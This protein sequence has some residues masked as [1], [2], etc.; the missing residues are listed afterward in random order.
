M[1][2]A[3]RA[4]R[5]SNVGADKYTY[6][7]VLNSSLPSSVQYPVIT[8]ERESSG[9]YRH[10]GNHATRVKHTMDLRSNL[11]NNRCVACEVNIR[12]PIILD[13]SCIDV[14]LSTGNKAQSKRIRAFVVWGGVQRVCLY[15][16]PVIRVQSKLLIFYLFA[17][18]IYLFCGPK[19]IIGI[20]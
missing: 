8:E 6:L 5:I 2:H 14:L 12:F 16:D 4:R 15:G 3:K 18:G 9:A 17:K 13:P 20:E 1:L 11:P 7:S 10:R 19:G